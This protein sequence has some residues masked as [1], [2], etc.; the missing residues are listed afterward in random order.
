MFLGFLFEFFLYVCAFLNILLLQILKQKLGNPNFEG[1]PF[2]NH[3]EDAKKFYNWWKRLIDFYKK[4]IL[5]SKSKGSAER[6]KESLRP[7]KFFCP[8]I[9][10][11]L[12]AQFSPNPPRLPNNPL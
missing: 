11:G 8:K 6:L 5:K 3:Q 10:P 7:Q 4:L 12:L 9:F 2:K 1:L